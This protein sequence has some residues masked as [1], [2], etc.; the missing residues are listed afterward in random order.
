MWMPGGWEPMAHGTIF[1]DYN[2]RG[3]PRGAGKAESVNWGMLHGTASVGVRHDS[4]SP[5]VFRRV[6]HLTTSRVSRTIS[7]WGNGSRGAAGDHQHP[8]N[9]FA[10]L[11]AYY[12]LPITEK[13]SWELYGGPSAEPRWDL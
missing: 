4:L 5:D 9:V 3:G 13:M 11:S 12:T 1:I 7:D 10:E 2:Q 8:H 6:A